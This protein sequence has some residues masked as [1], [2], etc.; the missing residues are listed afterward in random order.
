MEAMIALVIMGAFMLGFLSTFV[1]SRRLTESSVLHAAATTMVYGIIEQIKQLDYTTLLPNGETDPQAP[2]G[3]GAPVPPYVRVR[4]NQGTPI[5]LTTRGT[6]SGFTTQAP[7]TTPDASATAADVG[8]FDNDIGAIPLS[9]VSGATSQA[10]DLHIWMWID[11]ISNTG[12]WSAE[13]TAPVCD[14][15]E[16]KKIT[17]VYTYQFVDGSTTRTI[18]DREVFLRTRYD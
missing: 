15:S 13:G 6:A 14:A 17:I 12:T 18:R 2:T 10:L 7:S 9:T 5:W 11:Q 4:I 16:V 8:A 1:Q 3:V